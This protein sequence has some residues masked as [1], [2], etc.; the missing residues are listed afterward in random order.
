MAEKIELGK[1]VELVYDVAV[2]E[3]GEEVVKYRYSDEEPDAF[4]YGYDR[5]MID[6]F[7][8]KI[9]GL[10][11]GDKLDFYLSETA[12]GDIDPQMI[13][14]LGKDIFTVEGKFD[15]ENI[16]PGAEVPMRR[17]DGITMYGMVKDVNKDGVV[18]DFNHPFAG[19]R[20]HYTGV[21]QTVRKAT[22]EEIEAATPKGG[23]GGCGGCGG[24]CDSGSC[25]GCGGC[26]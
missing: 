10:E 9:S 24:N 13:I 8:E 18:M 6:E 3:A 22:E 17:S 25:G 5:G 1:Y 4:I 7:L 16:Y 26:N 23:C 11:E 12:F 15:S 20:A 14:L 2:V 19:K 21:V